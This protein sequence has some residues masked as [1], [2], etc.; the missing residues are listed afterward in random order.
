[1]AGYQVS[2]TARRRKPHKLGKRDIFTPDTANH[3]LSLSLSSSSSSL[4]SASQDTPV[5]AMQNV[6]QATTLNDSSSGSEELPIAAV[7]PTPAWTDIDKAEASDPSF[8]SEYAPEIYQYMRQREVRT[9]FIP[10]DLA[11]KI[12]ICFPA[13]A[14]V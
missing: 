2:Q 14:R 8:S 7:E 5:T 3:N 1:M 10:M 11:A 6:L 13:T 12:S 9:F 4:G